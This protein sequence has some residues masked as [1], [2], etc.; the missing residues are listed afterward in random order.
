MAACL[1]VL[2]ARVNERRRALTRAARTRLCSEVRLG[3]AAQLLLQRMQSAVG[4]KF[5]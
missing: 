2:T 5:D 4:Y 1:R 3:Y